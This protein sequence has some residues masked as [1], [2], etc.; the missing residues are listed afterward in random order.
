MNV[1]S[2]IDSASSEETN[3]VP[4]RKEKIKI[5]HCDSDSIESSSTSKLDKI[6]E[7]EQRAMDP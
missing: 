1:I 7:E 6:S 2:V 4:M 5:D 3:D